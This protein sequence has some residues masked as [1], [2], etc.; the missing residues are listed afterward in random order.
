MISALSVAGGVLLLFLGCVTVAVLC[1]DP[2]SKGAAGAFSR[3]VQRQLP[4]FFRAVASAVGLLWLVNGILSAVNWF[5]YKPHPV[6]QIGYVVLVAG[7]YGAFVVHG[8]PSLPNPYFSAVHKYI[9]AGVVALSLVTFVLA[10]FTNPGIVHPANVDGYARLYRYDDFVYS[11]GRECGTCALPKVARS[12]HC[13][14]CD[15]C[16]ARFDHHCIWL[17]TCVGERNYRWFF[18][19][20]LTNV[21]LL[22]YGIWATVAILWHDVVKGDLLNATFVLGASGERVK[23]TYLILGQYFLTVRPEVC[24][25]GLLC[26]VMGVVLTAFVGFHIHMTVVGYTTNESAKWGDAEAYRADAVKEYKAGLAKLTAAG[27]GPAAC[28][29]C[30]WEEGSPAPAATVPPHKHT[31]LRAPVEMPSNLYNRGAWVNFREVL[32][33]LAIAGCPAMGGEAGVPGLS[34]V[35]LAVQP[36]GKEAAAWE[37]RKAAAVKARGL[38]AA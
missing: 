24:C 1:I 26:A 15:R 14:V 37:A 19:Y 25:V 8:Y 5:L 35:G 23:A 10:S 4:T 13:R 32:F 3:F 7:G 17:N 36:F 34:P 6:I 27:K 20:L 12:K 16:V 2:D 38:K 28:L 9:A 29:T 18:A 22:W 11:A 21:I 30:G 31:Q 33:P